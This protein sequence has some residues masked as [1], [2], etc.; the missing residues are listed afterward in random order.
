VAEAA[1]RRPVD[2]IADQCPDLAKMSMALAPF[3]DLDGAREL[4]I[5]IDVF[6]QQQVFFLCLRVFQ[7]A[8][9]QDDAPARGL[10]EAV[11]P[12]KPGLAAVHNHLESECMRVAAGTAVAEGVAALSLQF[13]MEGSK[14]QERLL[15]G[16]P[17]DVAIYSGCC[18]VTGVL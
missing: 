13:L 4:D 6:S 16:D 14:E 18:D 3:I 5:R 11:K 12:V 10:V 9:N 2:W 15:P 8:V 17:A 7:Q 1:S